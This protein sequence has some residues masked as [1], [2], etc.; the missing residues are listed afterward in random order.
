MW[1]NSVN[2]LRGNQPHLSWELIASL[3]L[4]SALFHQ[5]HSWYL[6]K[7][8]WNW[9]HS[10]CLLQGLPPTAYGEENKTPQ[11][12]ARTHTK[13]VNFMSICCCLQT[14]KIGGSGWIGLRCRWHIELVC[15]RRLR[16]WNEC[17]DPNW[18][19]WMKGLC[20]YNRAQM[21]MKRTKA[22]SLLKA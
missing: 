8:S 14:G 15:H 6:M 2:F 20:I 3:I 19:P 18:A 17:C 4:P 11:T 21:M 16:L 7:Q 5:I 10:V 22:R 1:L 13:K 12:K 9:T